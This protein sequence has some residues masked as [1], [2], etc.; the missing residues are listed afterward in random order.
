MGKKIRPF[1]NM[2]S[3]LA[4]E[5]R[6]RVT[7]CLLSTQARRSANAPIA[8]IRA[9]RIM[10]GMNTESQWLA[11]VVIEYVDDRYGRAAAWVV[12]VICVALLIGIPVALFLYLVS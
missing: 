3:V 4:V 2:G 1:Q 11:E 10:S 9:A 7:R 6:L 12:A 8:D 5:T